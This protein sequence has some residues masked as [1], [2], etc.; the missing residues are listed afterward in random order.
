MRHALALLTLA[1]LVA[2]CPK[3]TGE[4]GGD[5]VE[6]PSYRDAGQQTSPPATVSGTTPTPTPTTDGDSGTQAQGANPAVEACVD[7]WLQE[8]KM[9]RYGHP[10]GTMYAGGSPLFNEATGESKDRL[11]YVFGRNPE[12]RKA[13]AAKSAQ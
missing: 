3:K 1:V 9:D 5:P 8:R 13:C 2:G 10:E 7:R 12:A 4:N 6:N 11:E